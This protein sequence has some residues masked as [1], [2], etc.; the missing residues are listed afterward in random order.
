[1]HFKTLTLC[2]NKKHVLRNIV[3]ISSLV[4]L[5]HENIKYSKSVAASFQIVASCFQGKYRQATV[6]IQKHIEDLQHDLAVIGQIAGLASSLRGK[7]QVSK[8]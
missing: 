1:M 6:E 4:K 3:L 5:I 7:H 8:F 2:L